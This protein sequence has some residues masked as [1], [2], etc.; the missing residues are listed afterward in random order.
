MRSAAHYL[1]GIFLPLLLLASFSVPVAEAQYFGRNK[2]QY[3]DFDFQILETSHFDIYHYPREAEAVKDLGRLSERWYHRHSNLLGHE[4]SATNPLII[5]ANHADFQQNDIVPNVGVG[6][7]GVTE[8]LRNRVIMPFA[9]AN[10]STN[11]VLGHELV[12]AFQYDIARTSEKIGGIR[13]T[14]QLPLWF[15]EGMAEYLSVGAEDTHTGMWLRDAVRREDIPSLK[16]LANSREY[17][18]YRYGH[19]VWTYIGGVWGDEV[20]PPLYST[21]AQKGVGQGIEETLDI[22][23]DSLS[24]LWQESVKRKYAETVKEHNDPSEVGKKILGKSKGTGGINAGP[25]LS[26]DGQYVAF[27]SEKNLFSVELFLADAESGEIIRS[28]TSTVTNPHL[29][30][31]RFI[32]SAGSWSPDGERFAAVVFAKGDNR[33]IIIDI[34]DGHT[35]RTLAFEEVGAITNPAWSPDGHKLAFSGSDGGYTDLY[36]YDMQQDSLRKLT[37]DRYSDLQ[38]AWSP[39]GSALAFVTDRGSGTD[40]DRLT[41]GTSVIGLYDLGTGEIDLM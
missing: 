34:E 17:F 5:Y 13:A 6:T 33:I 15:I 22:S 1:S 9:E 32:E 40:L 26:P 35:V 8:G 2:V 19:S 31:L 30:A 38:P 12:H 39:D 28:L 37:E 14:S 36:M 20:V 10:Q 21:S 4:I 16:D 3:E 29:N 41:F 18:P 25:S 27:I 23:M 11:H 24:T 7:G